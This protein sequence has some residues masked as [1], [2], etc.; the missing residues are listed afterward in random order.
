MEITRPRVKCQVVH[1]EAA[2]RR[3][4]AQKDADIVAE[5]EELLQH[6]DEQVAALSPDELAKLPAGAVVIAYYEDAPYRAVVQSTASDEQVNVRFVDF[7]NSSLCPKTSL[8][9]CNEKLSSYPHQSI[10]CQLH[11]VPSDQ[12]DKAYEYL[13]QHSD[14]EELSIALVTERDGLSS[15]LLFDKDECINARFGYDPDSE[16]TV[17]SAQV[18]P[19]SE[20]QTTEEVPVTSEAAPADNVQAE[21]PGKH[22]RVSCKVVRQR[23]PPRCSDSIDPSAG[24]VDTRRTGQTLRLC[25]TH[26]R[27]RRQNGEHR[28]PGGRHRRRK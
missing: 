6:E 14:S 22:R 9:A 20:Q 26:A 25:A 11:G 24:T 5:I 3:F 18:Q 12:V 19:T 23:S 27:V 17:A 2:Q 7:G 28:S 21:E 13:E 16:E 10:E 4:Y 15:V 1:I 8:K